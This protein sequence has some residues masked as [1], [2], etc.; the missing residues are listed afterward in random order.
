MARKTIDPLKAKEKKQK[1]IAAVLGVVFLGVAAFQ[2]P[3]LMKGLHPPAT[4]QSSSAA[5]TTPTTTTTAATPSL[6]APTL[7]GSEAPSAGSSSGTS[8]ASS[9]PAPTFAD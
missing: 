5:S 7:G 1:I 9:A 4:V 6:A 2:V 3:R 8:L